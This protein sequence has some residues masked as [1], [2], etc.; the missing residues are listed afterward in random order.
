MDQ[1][2]SVRETEGG[3]MISSVLVGLVPC[4]VVIPHLVPLPEQIGEDGPRTNP[5]EFK[6]DGKVLPEAERLAA[7]AKKDCIAF[8]EACLRR[9]NRE[10]KGYT[11]TMYKQE[12]I[13]G[14]LQKP[15]L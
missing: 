1:G 8:M 11:L 13:N 3:G 12:R 14:K 9:H 15:T 2:T 4:L 5:S 10:V 6:D 7:L